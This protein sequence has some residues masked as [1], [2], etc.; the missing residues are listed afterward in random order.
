M[1]FR[2]LDVV[3]DA[4]VCPRSVQRPPPRVLR[5][6]VADG[7]GGGIPSLEMA[8]TKESWLDQ[9]HAP[10]LAPARI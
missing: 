1:R 9:G 5:V 6:S 7:S 2:E 10:L 8:L 3:E 4:A